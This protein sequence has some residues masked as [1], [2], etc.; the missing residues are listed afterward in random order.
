MSEPW[1]P[2]PIGTRAATGYWVSRQSEPSGSGYWPLTVSMTHI[3]ENV[4]DEL[5]RLYE[6]LDRQFGNATWVTYRL[7]EVLPAPLEQKQEVLES[8]DIMP[9]LDTVARLIRT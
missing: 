9:C 7:M 8:T 5:G 2:S 1:L 6:N 3:L 4:L